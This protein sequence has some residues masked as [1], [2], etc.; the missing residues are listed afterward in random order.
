MTTSPVRRTYEPLKFLGRLFWVPLSVAPGTSPISRASTWEPDNEHRWGPT[1]VVRIPLTR[2]A[3]AVGVWLDTGIGD[4]DEEHAWRVQAETEDAE[5]DAYQA[6][7]GPVPREVW[8][9]ARKQIA[10]Q[11]LDPSEE[12]ELMQSLGVFS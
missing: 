7:N 4:L 6:V 10:A 1:L 5:Y 3:M 12:M 9:E 11:G 2:W 8:N